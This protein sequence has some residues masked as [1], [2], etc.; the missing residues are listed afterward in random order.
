M[1]VTIRPISASESSGKGAADVAPSKFGNA[2]KR[3]NAAR[4][5]TAEGGGAIEWQ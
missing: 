1:P 3:P 4:Q 2:E 5:R